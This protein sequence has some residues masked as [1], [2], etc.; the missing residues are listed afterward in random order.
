MA[1][2]VHWKKTT[3]PN[4]LGAYAFEDGKDMIVKVADVGEEEVTGKNGAMETCMVMHF[5]GDTKPLILNKT[6]MKRI[7]KALGTPYLDEWVDKKIQLY[8]EKNVPA[9]GSI[10]DAVRVREFAPQK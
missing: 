3:N 4:Y 8:V 5:V 6:N 7:E 9:F 2:H 1:E 10:T